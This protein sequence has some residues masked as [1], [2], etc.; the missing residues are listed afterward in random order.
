MRRCE[1]EWLPPPRT[2]E[3]TPEPD[4]PDEGGASVSPRAVRDPSPAAPSRAV[5]EP[6]PAVP[7]AS[8]GGPVST[9]AEH[10]P[11]RTCSRR[12]S[13]PG[14]RLSGGEASKPQPGA[15]AATVAGGAAGERPAPAASGG[16]AGPRAL[17]G[18]TAEG[19]SGSRGAQPPSVSQNLRLV[20]VKR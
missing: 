20:G 9:G 10:V 17:G 12:P 6:A 14:A 15:A 8:S 2:P 7:S 19:S 11:T 18:R 1:K 3:S 5:G 4:S 16:A 13:S